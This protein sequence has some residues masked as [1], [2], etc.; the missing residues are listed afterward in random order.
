M[1]TALVAGVAF[2]DLGEVD[3]L[4]DRRRLV[5]GAGAAAPRSTARRGAA[6]SS[7]AARVSASAL[8]QPGGRTKAKIGGTGG[9]LVAVSKRRGGGAGAV[10]RSRGSDRERLGEERGVLDAAGEDADGVEARALREGAG[11]R[12]GAEA[13][14]EADDAAEG[15]RPDHRAGGLGADRERRM[16]GGDGRGGAGGGAA[17]VWAGLAGLRVGAGVKKASSVVAV[18]PR[19]SAPAALS[20][21][22]TKAS[23]PGTRPASTACRSRSGSAR[24]R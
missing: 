7:S 5:E 15:G 12:D 24:C 22:T 14:L 23:S 20:R 21:S 11:A 10:A 13:R 9:R 3:P 1:A 16:P 2:G 8:S 6:S 17:G 18:L 4:T 19:I